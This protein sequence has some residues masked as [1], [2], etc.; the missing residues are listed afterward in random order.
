M[1][2]SEERNCTMASRNAK[3]LMI[4]CV[5][6]ERP[7]NLACS[8]LSRNGKIDNWCGNVSSFQALHAR[9]FL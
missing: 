8:A 4:I 6:S 3:C 1:R 9:C 7:D 5:T 2:L